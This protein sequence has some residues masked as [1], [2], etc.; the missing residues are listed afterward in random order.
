MKKLIIAILFL[1]A[2]TLQA[3]DGVFEKLYVTPAISVGCTFG[4]LF[5]LGVDVDLTTSVTNDPDKL[6]KAGLSGAYYL[7]LMRG[8]KQP[9]QIMTMN[10]MFENERMDLKAGYASMSYKWGLR[11]VNNGNLGAFSADVSFTNRANQIPWLGIKTVF[12]NQTQWIW[13]DQPY[14]SIYAK[15]KFYLNGGN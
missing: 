7:V 5:N 1:T 2:T 13:F 15:Q 12:Y 3:Q 8:A 10:L 9:H 6:R 4:G 14:Y 11:K